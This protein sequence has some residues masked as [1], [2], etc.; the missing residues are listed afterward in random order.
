MIPN[1]QPAEPVLKKN[2]EKGHLPEEERRQPGL[3]GE[4]DAAP[5]VVKPHFAGRKTMFFLGIRASAWGELLL[6]FGGLMAFDLTLGG[7]DRFADLCPHP[8]WIAVI[9]MSVQYGTSHGLLAVFFSSVFLLSAGIPEARYGQDAFEQLYELSIRPLSWAIAAVLLGLLQ[10]RHR[11]ERSTLW[12]AMTAAEKR[13]HVIT[14]AYEQVNK[15]K[16]RL[17]IQVAGQLKTVVSSFKAAKEL[18]HEDP[19]M[20]LSGTRDMIRAVISPEKF[21]IHTLEEQRLVAMVKSG[22]KDEEPFKESFSARDPLYQAVVG[23]KRFLSVSHPEER[24]ILDGQGVMAG[25]LIHRENG[26][27]GG[28]IKIEDLGFMEFN[29]TSVENFKALCEWA[30]ASYDLALSL[31]SA[32]ADSVINQDS[33]LF[34]YGFFPRQVALMTSLGRRLNFE[35]SLMIVRLENPDDLKL[36]DQRLIPGLISKATSVVMRNTDMAFDYETPGF[37]FALLLP[38]TPSEN[39]KFV[40]KKFD[41]AL[42]EHV[43]SVV[44]KAR[45]NI[46][47]QTLYKAKKSE[48]V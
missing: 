19:A 21:S 40:L 43:H 39:M 38:A 42:V 26:N 33:N 5:G 23:E 41:Q 3:S 36:E 25:P 47:T 24:E 7:S 20:V 18:E 44:P 11:S 31:Q 37:E 12:K 28:M 17:E 35:V 6:F 1:N 15:A 4:A 22:W 14:R 9:L 8:F 2:P 10:D 45:F 48:Q 30:G 34:S 27:I 13:G 16:E 32:R 29:V 46:S